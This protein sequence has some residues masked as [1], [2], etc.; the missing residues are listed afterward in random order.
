MICIR[1][2]ERET[3]TPTG[4]LCPSCRKAGWDRAH[5]KQK[6]TYISRIDGYGYR[7]VRDTKDVAVLEHRLVMERILGRKLIKGE[8]VHHKNGIKNDNDP[9][10]LELWVG[11]IRYGQRAVDISCPHCN[12]PYLSA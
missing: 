4:S 5:Q 9:T 12:L 6:T 1:C 3:D 10:N 2:L 11:P 8:S 7:W